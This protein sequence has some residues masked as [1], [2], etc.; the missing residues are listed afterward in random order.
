MQRWRLISHYST[1]LLK[2]SS[3][4]VVPIATDSKY[5]WAVCV[6]S[7]FVSRSVFEQLSSVATL[8]GEWNGQFD[9]NQRKA[10]EV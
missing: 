3:F 10:A 7:F 2:L 9:E 5:L 6:A 1:L 4:L 8:G